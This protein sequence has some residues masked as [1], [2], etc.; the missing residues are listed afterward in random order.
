MIMRYHD[1][2]NQVEG[3]IDT[4]AN[5]ALRVMQIRDASKGIHA[6]VNADGKSIR[7]VCRTVEQLVDLQRRYQH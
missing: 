7:V 2:D 3:R 5:T 6:K 1:I 4:T